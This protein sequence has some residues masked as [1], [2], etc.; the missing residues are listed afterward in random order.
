[1]LCAAIPKEHW[2]P[3]WTPAAPLGSRHTGKK[4]LSTGLL[5]YRGDWIRTSDRPAPS[6]LRWVSLRQKP[7]FLLGFWVSGLPSVLLILF[8]VLF[9]AFHT[10]SCSGS[11]S[12][13]A[14]FDRTYVLVFNL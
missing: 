3:N 12:D 4:P 10:N 1:S 8:P 5:R 7:P 2:T 9:P 11:G 6:T 14:I 13:R